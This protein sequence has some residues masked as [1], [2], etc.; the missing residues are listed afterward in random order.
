MKAAATN[1]ADMEGMVPAAPTIYS[2]HTGSAEVNRKCKVHV[3]PPLYIYKRRVRGEGASEPKSV[4]PSQ[5]L[6]E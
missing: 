1:P 3:N 5:R 4:R 6:S 2:F